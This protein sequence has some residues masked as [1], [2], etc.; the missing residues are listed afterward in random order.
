MRGHPEAVGGKTVN[1]TLEERINNLEEDLVN[2]RRM[3][4]GGEEAMFK[5]K[6]EQAIL[7]WMEKLEH[8]ETLDPKEVRA[9]I[10]DLWDLYSGKCDAYASLWR[11]LGPH[12]PPRSKRPPPWD[13]VPPHNRRESRGRANPAN[14]VR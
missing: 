3:V 8:A 5:G 9:M 6:K 13:R 14:L 7:N 12:P 1:R 4:R 2:L 10:D 11:R